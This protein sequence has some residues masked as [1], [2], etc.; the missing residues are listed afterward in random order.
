M[1]GMTIG[2]NVV[3]GAGTIVTKDIPSDTAA[4]GVP[5]RK[6]ESLGEYFVSV[7]ARSLGFG[8]LPAV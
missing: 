5:A 6:I 1:A 7:Q 3:V 2:N 4:A 8:N